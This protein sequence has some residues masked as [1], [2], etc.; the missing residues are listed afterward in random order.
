MD[1]LFGTAR[2]ILKGNSSKDDQ[3]AKKLLSDIREVCRDME[4]AESRFENESNSDL[5]DSCIFEQES[6]KARYSYLI[7][8]A[9]EHGI[10][11]NSKPIHHGKEVMDVG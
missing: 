7:K 3:F 1:K 6:L 11:C 8:C 9:K 4:L 10:S 2:S 5:I